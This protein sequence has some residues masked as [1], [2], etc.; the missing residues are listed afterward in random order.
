MNEVVEKSLGVPFT[1]VSIESVLLDAD[2][3]VKYRSPE[4]AFALLRE[5]I[6][7]SPRSISLRE[8]MRDICISQKN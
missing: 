7:R 8:K 4:K 1:E 5:S 3:F 6:E 2:L